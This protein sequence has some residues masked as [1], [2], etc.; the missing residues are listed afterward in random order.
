M[1]DHGPAVAAALRLFDEAPMRSDPS[2]KTKHKFCHIVTMLLNSIYVPLLAQKDAE[3]AA[4]K[5]EIKRK[6]AL[7]W[8][9]L[10]VDHENWCEIGVVSETEGIGSCGVDQLHSFAAAIIKERSK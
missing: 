2:E 3:L 8:K 7:A 6:D 1:T 4:A 5:A 9:M 10:D